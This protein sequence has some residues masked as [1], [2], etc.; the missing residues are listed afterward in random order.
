MPSSPRRSR[1]PSRVCA[2]RP[3]SWAGSGRAEW[4]PPRRT[5]RG[6]SGCTRRCR[7]RRRAAR[8]R[9][10]R[11]S[12]RA[13]RLYRAI[14]EQ[15]MALLRALS[16]LVEPLSL[17]E[18]FVDLEAGGRGLGRGVG[19]AGRAR[20]AR[21]H[22]GR[23][24]A[25]RVGG[26]RRLQDAREDRL[27]AG[28]AGR[29]GGDR[30]RAPSGPCSARCRCGILPG[31]GPATGDHLRR[32]GIT[33]VDEI[34]EAGRGRAGP[35]ARARRTGTRCTRMALARRRPARG[36]RAGGQVGVASRTPT[37]WTSIDRVRVGLEVQR[38]ADRCV[39]RLRAARAVGADRRAE[40]AAVR[41][42]HAHPLRDPARAHRRPGGGPGGAGA[43]AGRGGHHGR[44][45]AA[46]GR[47]V[48]GSPT[49]RRRTCSR[50]PRGSGRQPAAEEER[51]RG[52]RRASGHGRLPSGG[53]AAGHDVRH[54]EFGHGWVQGSGLGRVTVRFETPDS[55]PGRVR[56]FR[57][58]DPRWS[59]RIRCR[60][61]GRP[62]VPWTGVG[63]RPGDRC[64]PRGGAG[65][66]WDGA[67]RRP[68]P[69]VPASRPKSWSGSGG[70]AVPRRGR[71]GGRAGVPVRGRGGGPRRS[72]G[73]P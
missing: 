12:C 34:A 53:G 67:V 70:G 47:G 51:R 15:V 28:Q 61:C 43:A 26:P 66:R 52:G 42:L 60:W 35:A 44:R 2:G 71:S 31:V 73:R 11:T 36:G 59:R 21:R 23:H 30:A 3:S 20:A 6:C 64:R 58:D 4:S 5:R 72:P 22:T 33:T 19:A 27:R 50:R 29:P 48:A 69:S 57:T 45:A 38:L 32:A 54:A 16:P 14:S 46:G 25:H 56:T 41:L 1:R 18:A 9:T 37:T 7:W 63:R 39:R 65:R 49:S 68:R 24:G 17:D 13:S 55:E 10:R 62:G 40:G 8:A